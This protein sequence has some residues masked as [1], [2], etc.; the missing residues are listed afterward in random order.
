MR[1]S[2]FLGLA[3]LSISW[4][5]GASGDDKQD[6]P[7]A[8]KM[9]F[10]VPKAPQTPPLSMP[11]ERWVVAGENNRCVA[12]RNFGSGDAPVIF[13]MHVVPLRGDRRVVIVQPGNGSETGYFTYGI[14]TSLTDG[15]RPAFATRVVSKKDQ[16]EIISFR[17]DL[18]QIGAIEKS[19][20]LWLFGETVNRR[21]RL[22][23]VKDALTVL[24]ECESQLVASFGMSVEEQKRMATGPTTIK[25]E[26]SYFKASDYPLSAIQKSDG[27]RTT[28]GIEVGLDGMPNRCFVVESSGTDVL[29][30]K[31]CFGAKRF[32]F[33]PALD[34]Q[35][36]PMRSLYFYTVQWQM[37]G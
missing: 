17:L 3:A 10:Q 31:T 1:L 19:G 27:G 23:G 21:F 12:S 35:G 2:A 36:K 4:S 18:E 30:T 34:H 7:N 9:F 11:T 22:S 28:V 37:A 5:A 20:E 25:P 6:Q 29:D 8:L 33:H 32:R 16:K 15:P 13:A 26:Q 24:K 14:Q